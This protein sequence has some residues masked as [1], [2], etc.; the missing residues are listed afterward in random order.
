M[1]QFQ[2]LSMNKNWTS[3]KESS[4]LR[5]LSLSTGSLSKKKH[6]CPCEKLQK[7]HSFAKAPEGIHSIELLDTMGNRAKGFVLSSIA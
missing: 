2:S 3:K 7:K 6:I 5:V 4:I 1:T